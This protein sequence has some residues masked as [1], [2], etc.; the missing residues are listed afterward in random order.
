ME[1]AK[2]EDVVGKSIKV[3]EVIRPYLFERTKG[4]V[5]LSAVHYP[6][7]LTVSVGTFV[8]LFPWQEKRDWYLYVTGVSNDA[9][10]EV[11]GFFAYTDFSVRRETGCKEFRSRNIFLTHVKFTTS[12]STVKRVVPVLPACFAGSGFAEETLYY[13]SFFDADARRVRRINFQLTSPGHLFSFLASN[14]VL[15]SGGGE[16]NLSLFKREFTGGLARWADK[17][18]DQSLS[19]KRGVHVPMGLDLEQLLSLPFRFLESASVNVEANSITVLIT[20]EGQLRDILGKDW[21]ILQ[22]K[23]RKVNEEW[24]VATLC[25]PSGGKVCIQLE[26]ECICGHFSWRKSAQWRWCATVEHT[27]WPSR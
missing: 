10:G 25:I 20:S 12:I 5:L 16:R 13:D 1:D 19:P 23:A 2:V 27:G 17:W 22:T 9:E 11:T 4:K 8:A 6:G 7:R 26:A 3:Q 21:T 14:S 24:G 15:A 18:R